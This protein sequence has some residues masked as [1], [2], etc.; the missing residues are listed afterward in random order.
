MDNVVVRFAPSPTGYLHLGGARTALYNWLFA[1]QNGGKFRLRIEDTDFKRST[2]E[3][4]EGILNGLRWLGLNWDEDIVFQSSRIWRHRQLASKLLNEGKAYRCSCTPEQLEQMRKQALAMGLQPKYDRGCRNK[5]IPADLPHAIRF[6]ME[7]KGE[8]S[9]H[10]LIKGKVTVPNSELDDLIILRSDGM[11]TYNFSVVIDDHDMGITHVIRGDD[12]LTNTFRQIKIYEALG[13]SPPQF[14]HLPLIAGLSKRKG[15]ESIQQLQ[16]R[17][18]LPHAVVNYI[19]RM[20]W[21]WEDEEV[22]TIKQLLEK[23]SLKDVSSSQVQLNETKLLWLNGQHMKLTPPDQL[24]QYIRPFIEQRG[25][26]IPNGKW[27]EKAVA[28]V[29]IRSK[30]LIEAVEIMQPYFKEK[31]DIEKEAKEKFLT[32]E[33]ISLLSEYG[34]FIESVKFNKPELEEA[35]KN[36][37]DRKSLQLKAIAQPLRVALTG[38]TVGPGIYEIMEV[39]GKQ[40]V[41]KRLNELRETS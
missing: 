8:T 7:T 21:G 38:K 1:R 41:V 29:Q 32:H 24:A 35:T 13:W 22:F 26:K 30:T 34:K 33:K 16:K 17:G 14:A 10:D 28:S 27:L 19:A 23:F 36:F 25:W 40:K 5:N 18:F 2:K 31:V 39:L 9:F 37:L 6:K 4:V 15:S 3:S 12:H 20:G 11:P